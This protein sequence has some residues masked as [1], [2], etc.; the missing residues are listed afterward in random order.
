MARTRFRFREKTAPH[1][2]ASALAHN[3]AAPYPP[4]WLISGPSQYRGC[5]EDVLRTLLDGWRPE[6]ARVVVLAKE[7][8]EEV[9]GKDVRWLTAEWYG[10]Q[11]VVRRLGDA[12]LQRVSG[13]IP[14]VVMPC[15]EIPISSC[16]QLS[17]PGDDPELRLPGP[18]PYIPTDLSVDKVTVDEVRPDTDMLRGDRSLKGMFGIF[19]LPSIQ[20]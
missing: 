9:V 14:C 5:D 7:H 17:E 20:H 8:R 13:L 16:V 11:Y 15:A 10:T 1:S 2:Y 4:E 19:S 18:N 12:L 3:F 6:R